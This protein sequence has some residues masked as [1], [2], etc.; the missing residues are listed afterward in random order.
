MSDLL[1]LPRTPFYYLRHGQTDWNIEG[2]CQ[3]QTDIPM[4]AAGEAEVAASVA[5]LPLDEITYIVS[6]PLARAHQ[7]AQLAADRLGLPVVIDDGLKEAFWG[8]A[9]GHTDRSWLPAWREGESPGGAESFEQFSQRVV[10]TVIRIL[11]LPV[12]PLIVAHGGVYWAIERALGRDGFSHLP[13]G[14][15]L[16]HMPRE[17][18]AAL[19]RVTFV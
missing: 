9:E 2:R 13:N 4:N 19:W 16:K 3:G 5:R 18:D 11:S 14:T 6:S 8:E 7:S 1:L 10:D 12:T 15:L 17:D